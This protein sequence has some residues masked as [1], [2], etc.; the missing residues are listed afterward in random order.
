MY[1][2]KEHGET[3]RW[4]LMRVPETERG[5]RLECAARQGN[6]NEKEGSGSG[7]D[8]EQEGRGV[9]AAR[10][11]RDGDTLKREEGEAGVRVTKLSN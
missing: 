7:G 8:T 1:R 4:R 5:R 10:W 9:G 11:W 3:Q 6:S 2:E